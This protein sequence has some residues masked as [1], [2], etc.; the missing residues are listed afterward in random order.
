MKRRNTGNAKALRIALPKGHLFAETR[1]LF[2]N[3]GIDIPFETRDYRPKTNVPWLEIFII[4]PRNIP[5]L[6]ARGLVDAGVVGQD[7]V[8]D[9]KARVDDLLDLK[10]MPVHIVAA[11]GAGTPHNRAHN[12]IRPLRIASE[13]TTIARAYARRRGIKH[14][15]MKT[16]GST[17][18][19]VP[20]FADVIIDHVQ[21]GETLRKNDLQVIEVL[22]RSTAHLIGAPHLDAGRRM[23]LARLLERLESAITKMDLSYPEFLSQDQVANNRW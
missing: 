23:Q 22:M 14:T 10:L 5:G 3:A 4:K 2:S 8:I 6:V 1:T 9:E 12:G 19:F 17:E 7:L 18:C 13:Y 15:L 11:S 16:Y 20:D 21:T